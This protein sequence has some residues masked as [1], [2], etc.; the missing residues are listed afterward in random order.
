MR[1][2]EL[3]LPIVGNTLLLEA[4][5]VV[6]LIPESILAKIKQAEEHPVFALFDI[7]TE[8][9][10]NGTIQSD[11]VKMPWYKQLWTKAAVSQLVSKIKEK[12]ENIYIN[13]ARANDTR[14]VVGSII[15]AYEVVKQGITK[16][17]AIGYITDEQVAKKMQA[18]ELDICS[19]EATCLFSEQEGPKGPL[20]KVE[21]VKD[22]NGLAVANSKVT[23]P[24]F[25]D[26][27]VVAVVAALAKEDDDDESGKHRKARGMLTVTE[28]KTAIAELGLTPDRLFSVQELT[29]CPAVKGAIDSD[30]QAKI[31]KK[32]ETIKNLESELKPLRA[33]SFATK[34][35][36]LIQGSELVKN[37]PKSLVQYLKD[38]IDVD[39][40]GL[41]EAEA[42]VKVDASIKK[43]IGVAK[44]H[45]IVFKDKEEEDKNKTNK[46]DDTGSKNA[47][48]KEE[49][50][51]I[52][53]EDMTLP[54]NNPLIP[55]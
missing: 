33:L 5:E 23:K 16:A 38:V 51:E 52:D 3:K 41:S 11:Q 28:I 24:G 4:D 21:S 31:A 10:A 37:E 8:G 15:H 54:E 14:R 43:A 48:K 13:H 7:G 6:E 45:G 46:E 34:R 55:A 19:I 26:A 32:E 50:K 1:K 35:S 22:F 27:S 12:A 53:K 2:K 25:A 42:T 20:W 18:G 39:I 44:A 30:V 47:N 36:E 29:S 17:M 40:S 9:I 49:K